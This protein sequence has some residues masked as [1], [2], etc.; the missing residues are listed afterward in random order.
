M[1]R[2]VLRSAAENSD[3]SL[4][5]LNVPAE[6]STS[7]GDLQVFACPVDLRRGGMLLVIPVGVIRDDILAGGAMAGEDDLFGPSRVFEVDMTDE[8]ESGAIFLAGFQSEV[9]VLDTTDAVLDYL[10]EY[11]P[12]TDS[13]EA[14]TPF[15]DG[16]ATALPSMPD[17]LALAKTWA[18]EETVARI[19]FYSAREEPL[20]KTAPAKKAAAKRVTNATLAEQVA[21]LSAQV[22]LLTAKQDQSASAEIPKL[23]GALG[24]LQTP[25]RL[26][27]AKALQ[28][29]GPPPCESQPRAG[30]PDEPLDPLRAPKDPTEI[31]LSQQ[32]AALTALVTHLI[33]GN[34][35]FGLDT[36]TSGATSSSTKG[37]LRRERLQQD[38]AARQSQF[39]MMVQQQISKKLNPSSVLPKTEE[40]LQMK[41][42]PF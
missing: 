24:C 15:S 22:A 13:L 36:S 34:D 7:G 42:A 26:T 3:P 38:L 14:I 16:L 11:D 5:I 21:S 20:G 25:A 6:I 32:S 10:R 33:Q 8:D 12:V 1:E 17:L 4:L 40:E 41:G 28:M 23:P 9:L 39:F 18:R 37:T 35:P 27:P 31:A 19:H 29:V 30:G 2:R